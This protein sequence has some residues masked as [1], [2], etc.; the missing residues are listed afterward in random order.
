M[1]AKK[2]LISIIVPVK[3]E[4]RNI[5]EIYKHTK[6]V[7]KGLSSYAYEFVYVDDGST[8]NSVD[9]VEKLEAK[10][11]GVRLIRLARNFGKEI[12]TSAGLRHAQGDAAIMIDADLQH[13]PSVIPAFLEKW[14][15]GYDVVIGVRDSAEKHAGMVKRATSRWFYRFLN[16]ISAVEITP[17]ATD[18]RLMDRTVINEFNRFTEHNRMTRGLVDWLGFSRA[19]V[20]FVPAKRR[21][22]EATYGYAALIRLALNSVVGMSFFPLRL[23]GYLGVVITFISGVLGLFIF[24]ERFVLDDPL[25]MHFTGPSILATFNSFLI[26]IVLMSL[27]LI[28]LYIANIHSEVANR[29]LY[30]EKRRPRQKAV[31]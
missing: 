3:N 6:E 1:K 26:G 19:Y 8:D 5:L 15:E 20:E 27:G 9:E 16:M 24:V 31:D 10:D 7:F 30:V 14:D 13:P 28:A 12:A 4:E 18:F 25:H 21:Y 11:E 2:V 17:H 23:A 29:P 22:G